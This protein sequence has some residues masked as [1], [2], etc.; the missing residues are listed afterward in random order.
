MRQ[1][2]SLTGENPNPSLTETAIPFPPGPICISTSASWPCFKS[3]ELL[4]FSVFHDLRLVRNDENVTLFIRLKCERPRRRVRCLNFSM[5]DKEFVGC[6]VRRTDGA[7]NKHERYCE[8]DVFHVSF[9][10]RVCF[11]SF[12][13]VGWLLKSA[14]R[15]RRLIRVRPGQATGESG[16]DAVP[17]RTLLF[18]YQMAVWRVLGLNS[19]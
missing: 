4:S 5:E 7:A 11:A 14:A 16:T 9:H 8:R 1:H 12:L 15:R 17:M 10:L 19:R 6:L 3:T 18:R 2:E 13:S